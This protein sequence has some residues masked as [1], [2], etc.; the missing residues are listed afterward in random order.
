MKKIIGSFIAF[1]G[2]FFLV[3][4]V[5]ALDCHY[6]TFECTDS[7]NYLYKHN[8][9]Y[10][11]S[12]ECYYKDVTIDMSSY[13]KGKASDWDFFG[14]EETLKNW[15]DKKH[16]PKYINVTTM[17]LNI[18]WYG[19]DSLSDAE[20]NTKKSTYIFII[21]EELE[22]LKE[23]AEEFDSTISYWCQ[24][25]DQYSFK[26][27]FNKD[28]YAIEAKSTANVS[29]ATWS[30]NFTL[31]NQMLS[32]PVNEPGVCENVYYCVTANLAASTSF[33]IFTDSGDFERDGKDV[34]SDSWLIPPFDDSAQSE[35]PNST[36]RTLDSMF[37]DFSSRYSNCINSGS[38]CEMAT[39]SEIK[40]QT[41][42]NNIYKRQIYGD[43]CLEFCLGLDRKIATVKQTSAKDY[44]QSQCGF[45]AR[46]VNWI[47]KII[48]WIRYIVPALLIAL[49]VMD[50]IKAIASDSEDEV[51]KVGAKFVKRLIVAALIFVLP[52]LLEFLLG[53]FNIPVKDFCV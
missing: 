42:C 43:E 25:N 18:K 53:I 28:G 2:L 36:C 19:Y 13:N 22:K 9:D 34:C 37:S 45:S 41:L 38:S 52:L 23:N 29:A 24:Y 14:G 51:R 10:T 20:N 27:G 31:S 49:S 32:M 21:D 39:E 5:Y 11:I 48:K 26:I 15:D 30:Y 4:N 8:K 40:M 47:M 16:C 12:S 44:N 1:C 46:V 33:K 35:V 3:S 50:F 7:K 17:D 6:T